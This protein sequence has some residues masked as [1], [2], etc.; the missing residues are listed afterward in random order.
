MKKVVGVVIAVIVALGVVGFVSLRAVDA[1]GQPAKTKPAATVKVATATKTYSLMVGDVKRSYEVIAP[2]KALPKTAPVI[3]MLAGIGAATEF[4][5][6]RRRRGDQQGRPCP[7][8]DQR[9]G[10]DRLPRAF[11]RVVERHRLLRR[12]GHQERQ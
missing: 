6:D 8:R 12:G 1:S 5:C 4:R 7:L 2:V 11:V 9:P 10:G 3:V